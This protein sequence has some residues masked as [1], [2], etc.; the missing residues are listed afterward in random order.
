M[1][2]AHAVIDEIQKLLNSTPNNRAVEQSHIG[3]VSPYKLQCKINGRLCNQLGFR[4]VTIGT[5]EVFQGREKP[6]IILSTV[7]TGGALGF[8]DNKQVK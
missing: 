5:A 3:I 2:E 1:R 7:R 6:I 4:D 8:V